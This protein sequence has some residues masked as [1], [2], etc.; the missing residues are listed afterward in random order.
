MKTVRNL[1]LRAMGRET[2]T[3]SIKTDAVLCR[4]RRR[5]SRVA[6]LLA[7]AAVAWSGQSA[8]A[9]G[10]AMMFGRSPFNA[11][12]GAATESVTSNRQGFGMQFRGGHSTG[13]TA[14]R[15]DSVSYVSLMPHINMGNGMLFGDSRLAFANQDGM[16]YTFGGG[17]RHFI[18]EYDV[19]AGANGYFDNDNMTGATFRQWSV[20][21]ELLAH[22]WEARG[23]IYHTMGD[24]SEL[25]G[26]RIDQT[27]AAFV[28]NN[29]TFTRID[30]FA[31][32]LQGFDA[33]LGLLL[34]GDLAERFD[35]RAFGG[36][37]Y[38]KGENISQFA[39][40][41]SRLQAD[42]AQWLE[43]GLKVTDDQIYNTTVSFTAT[44]HFGGFQSQ[45]H[46]RRSAIQRFRE[47]V[48]RSLN[49]AATTSDTLIPGQT[50][51][52]PATNLP[53]NIVHVNSNDA[54]GPFLGTVEDPFNSLS[55]GL[56]SGADVVF[57]HAGSQF[58]ALPDNIVVLNPD[59]Q[60]LGEGRITTTSS[61]RIVSNIIQV[62]Q[63]GDLTLPSSPT[64]LASGLTASR[65]IISGTAGNAVTLADN[66]QLSGFILDTPT[67]IGVFSN[68]ASG[69]IIN[70]T[71]ISNAG[72]AGILLQNTV[73]TTT[74]TN[75]IIDSAVGPA[76][77]VDGGAG[78]ISMTSTSTLEDP[79]YG[80]IFNSSQE[81]ILIENM[82][83][84]SIT[85]VGTTVDDTGGAGVLIQ[86]NA[87]SATLDNLNLVGSTST[88]ISIL[89]SSGTYTFRNSLRTNTSIDGAT[90]Q[91]ILIDGL[92]ATGR[93]TFQDVVI[94]NRNA[95]GIDIR[96]LAGTVQFSGNVTT[97][98][99]AG[100][101]G[102]AI[103]V[104]NSL[105]TGAVTFSDVVSL[106]GSNENGVLFSGNAAGS[107]VTFANSLIVNS[108]TTEGILI[109]ADASSAAFRS[110]V[111]INQRTA[112]GIS[113]QNST[114]NYGFIG[115]TTIAN[116]LLAA[117]PAIDIQ[118]SEANVTFATATLQ[119]AIG[120]P[121]T[122][123]GV[124]LQN[125]IAGAN[126]TALITFNALNVVSSGGPSLFGL[127]NTNLVI[128][129]GTLLSTGAAAVDLENTGID[130]QFESV[131]ALGS[132][133]YGIRLVNTNF[134]GFKTFTV[135]GD[136]VQ[137]TF[138]SG[139]T[140]Q[141]SGISG[142]QME[143]A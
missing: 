82:A 74:I 5:R 122:G 110:G 37:Y 34:P 69:S 84:G 75:T 73:G 76:F 101:L 51:I 64:F 58:N 142:V 87:G 79:A 115:N 72:G 81:A 139:G 65:P 143:N 123:A 47:P 109:T 59:Q 80:A 140:I 21:A 49:V 102:A 43:L 106:T 29:I 57:V 89:N 141:G 27:S 28:G 11:P 33:E 124:H 126:N 88:G 22:R 4:P 39:G 38:Y 78:Q 3:S 63:V 13:P 62:S 92:G 90:N 138:G 104:S 35:V 36:G 25:V 41:S 61:S 116:T 112:Q 111:A 130:V 56:A 83:G 1:I 40:W 93:V 95:E 10:P 137:A 46:V 52:N 50:A 107:S 7:A 135:T 42:I 134:T 117:S 23:N 6:C 53:Y 32:A 68:G 48:R 131:S 118:N 108:P 96:N 125:N 119:N 114:G 128:N 77:H 15:V 24:T 30:T 91:G 105:A 85:M 66:S 129:D 20:G 17:Y 18:P 99:P 136:L 67:G 12:S 132:P 86:N 19:V 54:I 120:V 60:L 103:G 9:Q 70:D 121:G 97:T 16:V 2:S 14:G 113:I 8:D 44:V 55:T 45:E 31:E 127:D 26:R 100:G 71:L 133:D 94:D 98:A